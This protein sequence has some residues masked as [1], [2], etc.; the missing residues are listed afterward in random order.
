MTATAITRLLL[1]RLALKMM[2]KRSAIYRTLSLV[3]ALVVLTAVMSVAPASAAAGASTQTRVIGSGQTIRGLSF[4][5]RQTG[6]AAGAG[7]MILSTTDGGATWANNSSGI[8]SDLNDIDFV[9]DQNGWA[10]G[11][12]GVVLRTQDG[13]AT[14]RNTPTGTRAIFNSIDFVDPQNGWIVGTDPTLVSVVLATTDGGQTW[15]RQVA[16]GG[17]GLLDVS[18]Y[19]ADHGMTVGYFGAAFR[20][21]DGGVTWLPMQ[22]KPDRTLYSVAY[23]ARTALVGTDNGII[24]RSED[25][26]LTWAET[27]VTD[28]AVFSIGI[29]KGVAIAA[30][31]DAFIGFSDDAGSTW[32]PLPTTSTASFHGAVMSQDRGY[33][34]GERGTLVTVTTQK[35]GAPALQDMPVVVGT[36]SCDGVVKP[37]LL[38]E[39]TAVPLDAI[40]AD[41]D[42]DGMDEIVWGG[43]EGVTAFSLS[44]DGAMTE[45]WDFPFHTRVQK[46]VTAELDGTPGM[47]LVAGAA[48]SRPGREGVFAIDGE[49]AELL[50][51]KQLEGGADRLEVSDLTGDGIDDVA[52]SG[53]GHA[54]YL[55]DGTAAGQLSEPK[56]IDGRTTDIALGDVTGDDVA[57][58]AVTSDSG[59]VSVFDGVTFDRLWRYRSHERTAVLEAVQIADVDGDGDGEVVVAGY[60]DPTSVIP[61]SGGGTTTVGASSGAHVALFEGATGS[62][63]WDFADPGPARFRGLQLADLTG[64]G[65]L[66]VVAHANTS[67][68]GFLYALD[69]MGKGLLGDV[70]TEPQLLWSGRTR[71]GGGDQKVNSS[72]AITFADVSGDGV[73]DPIVGVANGSIFSFDARPSTPTDVLGARDGDVLWESRRAAGLRTV[74]PSRAGSEVLALSNDGL[75]RTIDAASGDRLGAAGAGIGA[76]AF[77]V[78]ANGNG[79]DEVAI[80]AR[81]GKLYVVG[82]DGE[83][84][85]QNPA[86]L[87]GSI[88]SGIVVDVD[89]DGDQ[90]IVVADDLG[91]VWAV[92]PVTGGQVWSGRVAQPVLSLAS[93][94][95]TILATLSDGRAVGLAL[96]N[97]AEIW[98]RTLPGRA[99]ASAF[100]AGYGGFIVPSTGSIAKGG[101][102]SILSP[103]D[104]TTKNDVA[105]ADPDRL[106][107]ADV[108]GEGLPELLITAGASIKAYDSDLSLLWSSPLPVL[109]STLTVADLD[110]DGLQDVAAAAGADVFGIDGRT[111]SGLWQTAAGAAPELAAMD[112]DGNGDDEVIAFSSRNGPIGIIEVGGG[113]ALK[114]IEGDGKTVATCDLVKGP[115][116]LSSLDIDGDGQTEVIA[117]TQTGGAYAFLPL[118]RASDPVVTPSPTVTESAGTEVEILATTTATGQFTD[119]AT[120]AARVTSLGSGAPLAGREVTFLIE[121]HHGFRTAKGITGTDGIVSLQQLLDLR[122]G[123]FI[124]SATTESAG[125]SPASDEAGL[126]VTREDATA[127][128]QVAGSGS[129]RMLH[130]TLRDAD[131]D[132]GVAERVVRFYVDNELVGMAKTDPEGNAD[133]DLPKSARGSGRQVRVEFDGDPYFLGA[134]AEART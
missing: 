3:G 10:V 77:G 22:T 29:D 20:T 76:L 65:V 23:T 66:D 74:Y 134:T 92:D 1:R 19:D 17:I 69:G 56:A 57:D 105:V 127:T 53:N 41:L 99:Y 81:S 67:N 102:I 111:G 109:A 70:G 6:W 106:Q 75:V 26:G 89:S 84:V 96:D 114:V 30:G 47:E 44:A 130:A 68:D 52:A 4:I 9:D 131:A 94:D 45:L 24:V 107:V 8:T 122:P 18:F 123:T 28:R 58:L 32:A 51:A 88:T 48:R 112:V 85:T 117:G 25:G 73:A 33:I 120:L 125:E 55:L 100:S 103:T 7:G 42:G 27:A 38:N 31:K 129:S 82:E 54:V 87:P 50:W 13:G 116:Q 110:G 59:F 78:D 71:R 36:D 115:S 113:N 40:Y 43:L 97:G 39:A 98:T 2:I 80:G 11:A 21:N 93:G 126:Q 108:D 83:V 34:A 16:Q 72:D 118:D 37:H 79:R 121:G 15:V 5:D 119:E 133:L 90:E 46:I 86:F 64:D 61:G 63:D 12:A 60:G 14:W 35:S 132:G 124:L 95:D 62:I 104:G 91:T 101:G 128:L 49:S